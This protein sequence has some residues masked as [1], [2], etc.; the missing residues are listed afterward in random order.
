LGNEYDLKKLADEKFIYLTTRGRRTGKLHRV[1]LWFAVYDGSIYLSH[2]GQETDWMKNI[3]NNPEVRYEIG[4]N[5]FVGKARYLEANDD[6]A[7]EGKIAL[8]L[9]Y[10]GKAERKV[11][12]DW[13]SLSTLILIEALP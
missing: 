5:K 12:E 8:Y 2:E 3:K 11:I 10:Y 4:E 9:K 1:E 7:Q 6:D 13:F